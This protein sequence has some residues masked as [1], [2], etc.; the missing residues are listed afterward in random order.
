MRIKVSIEIRTYHQFDVAVDATERESFIVQLFQTY[1]DVAVDAIKLCGCSSSY[2]HSAID[3]SNFNRTID[4][5]NSYSTIH[6]FCMK[7]NVAGQLQ[8]N[9]LGRTAAEEA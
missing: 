4:R 2:L 1:G 3:P 8:R 6:T 7:R 5:A 9:A